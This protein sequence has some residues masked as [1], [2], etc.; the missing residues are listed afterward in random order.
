MRPAS[1][2]YEV[3]RL[4]DQG[5]SRAEIARR[6][7]ISR[8]TVRDWLD[9]GK[10][11]VLN[12]PMRTGTR[13]STRHQR[14]DCPDQCPFRQDLDQ[15]AYAYVLGQ[16]LGDGCIS[17]TKTGGGGYRLRVACCDAYP[18]IMDECATA[19]RSIAPEAH[20]RR[21][22]RQGCTEVYSTWPHWPCL[23]PHGPGPKHTR[24]ITLMSWQRAI[25]L[26]LHP[27][28]LVRGLI[29]SDGCRHINRVTGANGM[30][31]AY[32]RY[33]FTNTSPDIRQIFVDACER[34]GV[35]TRQMNAVNISVA[36]RTSVARLDEIVG[37]KS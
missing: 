15:R 32:S 31:Y 33:N 26:V 30:K 3:F 25:A 22:P 12:R 14:K 35:E 29:H 13:R 5:L 28:Q 20:V 11:T 9:H 6:V 21:I 24:P 7:G 10:T 27:D 8:A 17:Q 36:R 2:V 19:M 23:L 18:N 34:L 16:Y 37:P 4:A 1:D